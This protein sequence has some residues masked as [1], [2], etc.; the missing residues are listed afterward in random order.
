MQLLGRHWVVTSGGEPFAEV[1]GDGVV[2][3][4]TDWAIL[5]GDGSAPYGMSLIGDGTEI[6]IWGNIYIDC[7]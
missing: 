5:G 7:H 3:S 4:T 2:E 6:E 1:T